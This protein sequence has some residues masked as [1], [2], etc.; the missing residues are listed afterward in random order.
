MAIEQTEEGSL[1]GTYQKDGDKGGSG[2][3]IKDEG[4]KGGK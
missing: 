1:M 2:T 3:P 4:D